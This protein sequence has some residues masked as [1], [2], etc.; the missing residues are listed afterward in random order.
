MLKRAYDG[1]TEGN[2]ILKIKAT[3]DTDVVRYC[4]EKE[5]I[6][7]FIGELMDFDRTIPVARG[8]FRRGATP[9]NRN[10]I[11]SKP[12]FPQYNMMNSR[13]EVPISQNTQ[14]QSS[15]PFDKGKGVQA[16]RSG[17][18]RKD[19]IQNRVNPETGK[20]VRSYLNYQGKPVFIKRACNVCE[21]N[22]IPNQLHFSF[23]CTNNAVPRAHAGE[24]DEEDELAQQ[25][26]R[27]ESGNLTSY[28]FQ[29]GVQG[30]WGYLRLDCIN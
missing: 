8:N 30:R 9:E 12:V 27:T 18:N 3:M 19:S 13:Y 22:G 6:D 10:D 2:I 17:L 1:A 26:Y 14:S 16:D 5:N 29:H 11:R 7:L 21:T 4:K 15:R 24:A 23:E 20:A 28:N 25:L